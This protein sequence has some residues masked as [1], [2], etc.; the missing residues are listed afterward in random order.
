MGS[1]FRTAA[2][3]T[4][5]ATRVAT[6]ALWGAVFLIASLVP[7]SAVRADLVGHGGIVRAVAVSP[8]GRRIATGSFDYS[9]RLWDFGEQSELL[10][11]DGHAGPV[12]AIA[13]VDAGRAVSASDDGAIVWNLATG[14]PAFR[15]EGHR[16][17]TMGV[18]VSRD[19][20]WIATAGW[21]RTVRL[22]D[23]RDGRA[24]AVLTTT[25]P[26]NAVVFAAGGSRIAAAGHDGFLWLWDRASG[27]LKGKFSGHERGVTHLAVSPDGKRLLSAGIDRTVRLWD[28]EQG[29]EIAAFRHHEVQVYAVAFLPDG[30][31]AASAGRD[32][33]VT[34]FALADGKVEREIKAH[35]SQI[36]GVAPSP[37]GRFVVTAASD[38]SARVWHLETGDRIGLAAETPDEA[39]PWLTDPHPGAKLFP[40]CARCHSLTADGANKSGPH[41]AGLF[42]RKVGSVD[43]YRYSAALEKGTFV[44]DEATLFRLF[45]D[46]PDVMLPGTKMP[47]QRITNAEQLRQ[48][49]DYLK[50]STIPR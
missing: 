24:G 23:A 12:N 46:G 2:K 8:D 10:V 22:W 28:A 17:K 41:L 7:T 30:R 39:Q 29:S 6:S 9:A 37:D 31:R 44:W 42:G 15:F 1:E 19:G 40:K 21:D 18:A 5:V 38:G 14:K 3:P 26:M 27:E 34:I 25:E 13:F 36:W 48:L 35:D 45:D 32:G 20:R 33:I 50:K 47:V 43:D 16:H 49:I 4:R 11:L